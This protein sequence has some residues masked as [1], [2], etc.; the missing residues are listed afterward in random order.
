MKA[1]MEMDYSMEF[2]KRDSLNVFQIFKSGLE[3]F[4]ILQK[5][6]CNTKFLQEIVFYHLVFFKFLLHG[7][8]ER[9]LHL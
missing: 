5:Y 8:G 3:I 1:R 7:F 2:W 6:R 9:F 4:E